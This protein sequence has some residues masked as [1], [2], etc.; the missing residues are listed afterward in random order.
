MAQTVA[1]GFTIVE[2]LV[3]IGIIGVLTA[4]LLPAVNAAREAARRTQCK[5]NI[6]QLALG[7]NLFEEANKHWPRSG[8]VA[9]PGGFLK[10][11]LYDGRSG[12]MQSWVVLILP[13]I[14]ES[15]LSR[16]INRS[17]SILE[18]PGD[19]Q[20][21][22]IGT[23]LC[24]SDSAEQIPF[25]NF[26]FTNDKSL[27]KGNYAAYVSPQHVEMQSVDKG[28]LNAHPNHSR[29]DIKDGTTKTIVLAEVRRR[30]REDDARGAWA[31][32]W[33]GSS[34]LAFDLHPKERGVEIVDDVRYEYRSQFVPDLTTLGGTQRPNNQGPAV[35]MLYICNDAA[36]AQFVEMPCLEYGAA[37][38]DFFFSA[39][40][41]SQHIGGVFGTCLDSSVFFLKDDVDELVMAYLISIND[42]QL[43][44]E[45]DYRN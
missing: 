14:E 26:T 45:E 8:V 40:P 21:R 33:C 31:L 29:R 3:V 4:L 18:Q 35:D 34:L 1:R 25:K 44:N 24:P 38:G 7:I 19:P 39:A 2:L 10:S 28:A 6:R 23:M 27:A 30:A 43:I 17:T 11:N 15:A 16:Q 42:G 22:I 5:N 9:Q 41:R 13:Y 36:D 20:A 12:P 37:E 32:P